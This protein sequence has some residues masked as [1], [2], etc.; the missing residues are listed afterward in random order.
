MSRFILYM[1]IRLT[2]VQEDVIIIFTVE[3]CKS[4]LNNIDVNDV[5]V[6]PHFDT[7][8]KGRGLDVSSYYMKYIKHKDTRITEAKGRNRFMLY[9]YCEPLNQMLTIIIQIEDNCQIRLITIYQ[10]FIW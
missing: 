7:R 8:L 1:L 3:D 9:Y 2:V 6:S 10:V 4:I 5:I